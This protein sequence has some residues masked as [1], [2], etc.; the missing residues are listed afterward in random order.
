MPISMVRYKQMYRIILFLL[1]LIIYR[2]MY[3]TMAPVQNWEHEKQLATWAIDRAPPP[4]GKDVDAL[5]TCIRDARVK[6]IGY[7]NRNITA[8]VTIARPWAH[9]D[10]YVTVLTDQLPPEERALT[11]IHECTHLVWCTVDYAYMGDS[12]FIY[13]TP[14][15]TSMNADSFVELYAPYV[16]DVG[17]PSEAE[18]S[19]AVLPEHIGWHPRTRPEPATTPTTIQEQGS[20]LLRKS[21]V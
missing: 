1:L 12:V 13:L 2:E 11:L 8:Y 18:P 16:Y 6:Y 19:E 20:P 17:P 5:K 10:I 3:L 14:E 15:E 21:I 7:V 9:K 4:M